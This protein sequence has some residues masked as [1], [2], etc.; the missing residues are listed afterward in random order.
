MHG[1]SSGAWVSRMEVSKL[2]GRTSLTE[3]HLQVA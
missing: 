3:V 2:E 1:E